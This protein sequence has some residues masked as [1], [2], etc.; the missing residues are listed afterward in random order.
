MVKRIINLY[1]NPTETFTALKEKPDWIVPVAL[2]IIVVLVVTLIAMP[3]IIVPAQRKH[4]ES[5]D[6]IPEHIRDKQ[7]ER[8]EGAFPYITTPLSIIVLSFILLFLQASIFMLAFLIFGDRTRFLNVLAV[9]GYSFLVGIPE[10]ILRGIL[11]FIK[12]TPHVFTSLVLLLPNL[13]MKS[14]LF[15]LLSRLDIFTIWKLA[16]IGLGCSII[17]G[18][19]RKKSFGLVFGLWILWLILVF[20]ASHFMPKGLQIG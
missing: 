2:S 6:E 12:K 16:L 10:S 7:L 4:L 8:L 15:K 11:M 17:Y 14:P 1:F 5:M 19:S 13:D 18:V 20:I 3:K 9:V